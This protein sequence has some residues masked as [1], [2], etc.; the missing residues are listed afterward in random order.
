MDE[1]SGSRHAGVG[2]EVGRSECESDHTET[3]RG[4]SLPSGR[5]VLE[6]DRPGT[7]VDLLTVGIE[8]LGAA[9]PEERFFEG[10]DTELRAEGV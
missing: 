1:T 3:P 4:A 5:S 9:V 10:L 2:V 7:G 8:D 6:S